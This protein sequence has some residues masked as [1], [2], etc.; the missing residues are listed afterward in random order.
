MPLEWQRPD[1]PD[2][3]LGSKAV[4]GKVWLSD[5]RS[6]S[7]KGETKGSGAFVWFAAHRVK[8]LPTP[9]FSR[10]LCFLNSMFT[11]WLCKFLKMAVRKR[12]SA[13]QRLGDNKSSRRL[14]HPL[15]E[16]LEARIV[17]SVD[18]FVESIS[19]TAPAGPNTNATS[20]SYTV[21]FSEAVTGVNAA[22]FKL[23]LGGT[24]AATI[25]QVTPVS[26]AV[27]TVAISGITGIG[28]LG[29]NL[30]DNGS[31]HDA[32]GNHLTQQNGPL[33]LQAQQTFATFASPFSVAVGDLTGNGIPDLVVADVGV[34]THTGGSL[35]SV[36]L[37]NGNGTFQSQQTLATG[38]FPNSL[39]LSDLTG[40]GKL[41][42]VVN[43]GSNTVGVLL[44]NGNG[45]F[46]AQRTIAFG[47]NPFA[48]VVGDVTGDGKADIVVG[49]LG[50]TVSVLLGNGNGTFQA[51]QT[52]A[53]GKDPGS[54]AVGD[55][56]GDG[57]TDLV[58]ANP[59]SNTVSVLLGNGNGT[60]QAQQ[61]FATGLDPR[62][63]TLCDLN[64]D[65]I[66]D[67]VVDN[68]HSQSVSVLLGN[69]NGTFQAQQTFASGYQSLASGGASS[70]V[71]AVGDLTGDGKPDIVVVNGYANTVNVLLG[72]GNGTFQSPQTFATGSFPDGVAIADLTGDGRS[73]LVVVNEANNSVSVLVNSTNGNFTGQVYTVVSG[74][75]TSFAVTAPT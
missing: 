55:L 35:L 62:S 44:G 15:F 16:Q 75:G 23:A 60:F 53:A 66:P 7:P 21:T 2:K 33:A 41:D 72:N 56:T 37:G 3:M 64:G 19:C 11:R 24:V 61:T 50:G 31:I 5:S 38:T 29:L 48:V 1:E 34:L 32:A 45:T 12:I 14:F 18:P 13:G 68:Y 17:P 43:A 25:T 6:I 46:Q 52:F 39:A 67:V 54:L 28:T 49:N 10:P 73:D 8:R 58:A 70:E 65:G 57:K 74:T 59:G 36:L 27:Y 51:Q 20:V 69:G 71:A 63:V 30:V 42:I 47:V 22:D 40:D 26:G 9:L 4:G